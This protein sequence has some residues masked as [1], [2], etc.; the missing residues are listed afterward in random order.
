MRHTV[1]LVAVSI[2]TTVIGCFGLLVVITKRI[3]DRY[4]DMPRR[5][6]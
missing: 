5:A 4:I 1:A 2:V 3:L 6:A